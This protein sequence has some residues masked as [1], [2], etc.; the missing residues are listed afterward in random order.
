MVGDFH[1]N[2]RLRLALIGTGIASQS[3]L[4]DVVTSEDMAVV[5]LCARRYDHA[6]QVASDFGVP[7]IY[8]DVECMLHEQHP[9]AVVI[10]TPP[11]VLA[12]QTAACLFAGAHVL[13]EKPLVT[14]HREL[15]ALRQAL[16]LSG[17]SLVVG[18]TRRYRHA[19]SCARDWITTGAIGRVKSINCRWCGPYHERYGPSAS[20]YRSRPEERIAGVLLDTGSH[21]IDAVLCLTGEIGILTNIHIGL[22]R[23]QAVDIE[24]SLVIHQS[25]GAIVSI[26]IAQG[27]DT[28]HKVVKIEGESG[29]IT[30]TEDGATMIDPLGKTMYVADLYTRRPVDD[31]RAIWHRQP[32][33]GASLKEAQTVSAFLIHAYALAKRPLFCDSHP[34]QRPRAKARAKP[35]GAC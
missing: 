12:A 32:T 17:R 6:A 25:S 7:A 10:A 27:P 4:L 30:L 35:S 23:H 33:L 16:T 18:Y 2:H 28:E 14:R 21:I 1:S 11:S 31:L 3:H 8:T 29:E 5:A 9:D 24:T 20:S 19:W 34:W 15:M 26:E 22:D 13:A